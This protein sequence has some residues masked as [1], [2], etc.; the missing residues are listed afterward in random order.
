MGNG[1]NRDLN[2]NEGGLGVNA[3]LGAMEGEKDW[4]GLVRWLGKE[5]RR[6]GR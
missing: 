5:K 4:S 1:G 6:G 3:T 2:S